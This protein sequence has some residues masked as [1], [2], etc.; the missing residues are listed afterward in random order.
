M[1]IT[2]PWSEILGLAL[3]LPRLSETSFPRP[4]VLMP[5]MS[6]MTNSSAMSR[7]VSREKPCPSSALAASAQT[8]FA[9][10]SATAILILFNEAIILIALS[11]LQRHDEFSSHA[12]ARLDFK[13][14]FVQKR[15]G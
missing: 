4:C 5:A 15:R 3:R 8:S 11:R 9:S 14:H 2:A 10:N 12:V 1:E 13:V 6:A 7:A